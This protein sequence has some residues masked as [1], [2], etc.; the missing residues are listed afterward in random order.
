MTGLGAFLMALRHYC[1]EVLPAVVAG[2]LIS[3]IIY[4]VIPTAWVNRY[5]GKKGMASILVAIVVGAFLPICCWGSLPIAMSFYKKGAGLG[6][7]MAFLIAAPATSVS[8]MLVTY[9]LL[10]FGFMIYVFFAV[11]VMGVVS[12]IIGDMLKFTPRFT[13]KE[14]CPHCGEEA[15]IGEPHKHDRNLPATV[16]AILKYA[17]W[18]MP[19]ELGREIIIGLVLAALIASVFPVGAFIR[20]YLAGWLGYV[21]SVVFGLLMY[22]CSTASVPLVDA[23]IKQGLSSSAGMVLLLIGPITSYATILVLRKE[24]GAKILLTYLALVVFLSVG[25]GIG[26]QFLYL[27]QGG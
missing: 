7:V 23:L 5:L 11:I 21:F 20:H 27:H 3:G 12:G 26:Y 18:E 9:R 22:V 10:G 6:P 19:K 8:A 13:H 17:F 25:L 2:F 14:T 15:I 4:E 1:I 16:R 24:F